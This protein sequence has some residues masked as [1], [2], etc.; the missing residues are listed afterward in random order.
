MSFWASKKT[1]TKRSKTAILAWGKTQKDRAFFLDFL[2]AHHEK[3]TEKVSY[4]SEKHQEMREG[5]IST[6]HVP[7]SMLF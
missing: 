6:G 7:T 2:L 5:L 4:Y 3:L 1:W